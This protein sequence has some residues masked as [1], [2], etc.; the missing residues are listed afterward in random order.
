MDAS[1]DSIHEKLSEKGR[2]TADKGGGVL[3]VP[4]VASAVP[5]SSPA[6]PVGVGKFKNIFTRL[7]KKD[8][9][10]GEAEEKGPVPFAFWEFSLFNGNNRV[11]TPPAFVCN[12]I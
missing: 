7:F 5:V 2:D 4:A 1:K 12:T 8:T 3:S 6:Q 10:G 9:A 11:A